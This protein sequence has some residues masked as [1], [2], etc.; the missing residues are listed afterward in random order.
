MLYQCQLNC[1]YFDLA[2]SVNKLLV[3]QII[4][5]QFEVNDHIIA[6]VLHNV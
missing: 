2:F 6:H 1:Y 5:L 4:S 3:W